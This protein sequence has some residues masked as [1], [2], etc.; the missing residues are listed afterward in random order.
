MVATDSMATTF[1]AK[2]HE[3]YFSIDK[4]FA[5]GSHAFVVSGGM[6]VSVELSK[7]FKQYAE[8]RRLVGVEDIVA[9]AGPYLSDLYRGAL[10]DGDTIRKMVDS[11]QFDRVYFVVGGYS[12]RSANTPYQLALWGSEAGQ[13]P[14]ERIK[15]GPSVT[16]PRTMSGE[17]K[18]FQMCQG[19][20]LLRELIEFAETFLHKQ[21]QVNPQIG[22]P[23]RFG[24]VTSEGF[25]RIEK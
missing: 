15:I 14:L 9:T 23:F 1:D 8:E 24:T 7:R 3:S 25:K 13:L 20:C 21:A 6:G 2:G 19:N 10:R 11:G 4:L 16:V 18:L 17:L 22:P 12:F 5:V